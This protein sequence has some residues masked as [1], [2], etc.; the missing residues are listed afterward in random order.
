VQRVVAF[1][2]PRQAQAAEPRVNPEID[3]EERQLGR[4]VEAAS[5]DACSRTTRSLAA[6]SETKP[7]VRVVAAEPALTP[8][9]FHSR[10]NKER[11][12]LPLNNTI[13][14]GLRISVPG[15]NPY[16]IIERYVDEIVLVE[17]EHIVAGMRMLAHDAK[18]DR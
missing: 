8:K 13:A 11:T 6:G 16:P 7:S 17:D 5:A 15:Q 9:Y 14:D 3:A 18:L 1:R 4:S 10:I 2:A 12:S